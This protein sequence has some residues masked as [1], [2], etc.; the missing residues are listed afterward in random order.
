MLIPIQ[1]SPPAIQ[2]QQMTLENQSI[3][4]IQRI[5]TKTDPSQDIHWLAF[6]SRQD[7][8]QT[9]VRLENRFLTG[10]RATGKIKDQP[11]YIQNNQKARVSRQTQAGNDW[12]FTVGGDPSFHDDPSVAKPAFQSEES[13]QESQASNKGSL[14]SES[15]M[16]KTALSAPAQPVDPANQSQAGSLQEPLPEGS[17][18]SL[19]ST[20]ASDL[21]AA[22]GD[23]KAETNMTLAEREKPSDQP[24]DLI[25]A[26]LLN[27]EEPNQPDLQGNADPSTEANSSLHDP[28]SPED[29]LNRRD[30]DQNL[31]TQPDQ[32]GQGSANETFEM[33]V[34]VLLPQSQLDQTLKPVLKP[35]KAVILDS[36]E[37]ENKL[38]T[39]PLKVIQKTPKPRPQALSVLNP[40]PDA[41]AFSAPVSSV[42]TS[43]LQ[44]VSITD[45]QSKYL[46]QTS[47]PKQPALIPTLSTSQPAANETPVLTQSALIV[48]APSESSIHPLD[49]AQ[50]DL[51]W[52]A[53]SSRGSSMIQSSAAL[54]ADGEQQ[55]LTVDIQKTSLEP[56]AQNSVQSNG[57]NLDALNQVFAPEKLLHLSPRA[58]EKSQASMKSGAILQSGQSQ[59]AEGRKLFIKDPSSLKVHVDHGQIKEVQIISQATKK[60]Y[61]DLEKAM[62]AEKNTAFA[63]Q[64]QIQ[65]DSTSQITTASWTVVPAASASIEASTSSGRKLSSY[66]ALDGEGKIVS[67]QQQKASTALL[68][69]EFDPIGSKKVTPGETLRLYVDAKPGSYAIEMNGKTKAVDVMEDELGQK[70]LPIK[71]GIATTQLKVS[72]NGRTIYNDRLQT[73]NPFAITGMIAPAL[74]IFTGVLLDVRRRRLA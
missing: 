6:A 50:S 28:E 26:D 7:F 29:S 67:Y 41:S 27:D 49:P 74:G 17:F 22:P 33:Q 61:P 43:A 15:G 56:V 10:I 23:Q 14:S 18:S 21:S 2:V 3:G 25:N 4:Q 13:S 8:R 42:N 39:V 62:Q 45:D 32:N 63:V 44:D 46:E 68:C 54:P 58:N 31:Q 1:A 59:F 47:A 19:S 16:E 73:Q 38:Q 55:V 30:T 70:Y 48:Q 66:Y 35:S 9:G 57:L 51:S 65:N 5:Q 34:P 72:R 24:A 71:A 60:V 69:R 37:K 40:K 11:L 20:S 53:P 12:T 52:M 64:A 36:V